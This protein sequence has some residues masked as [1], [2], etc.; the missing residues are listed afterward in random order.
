MRRSTAAAVGTV[1]GAALI[2]AVRLGAGAATVAAPPASLSDA[3]APAPPSPSAS[4]SGQRK[5]KGTARKK[6]PASGLKD[7]TYQGSPQQEPYGTV[8]VVSMTVSSGKITNT[9]VTYP[10]DG[11]AAQVNTPAVPKLQQETLRAQSARID[12]VS[13]AT[14][15]SAAYKVSLQAALDAAKA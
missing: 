13:G 2:V 3:T 8:Q 10:T 1:T 5:S 14:Y 4:G 6:T 7:G 12:A 9:K 11:Y 15:T